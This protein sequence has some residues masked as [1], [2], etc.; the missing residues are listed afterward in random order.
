MDQKIL[1][2]VGVKKY[3][4]TFFAVK[5]LDESLRTNSLN[6]GRK[7]NMYKISRGLLN[8]SYTFNLRPLSRGR[9]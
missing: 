2:Q 5:M 6:T 3:G 7:L 9:S 1:L 8:A 4:S